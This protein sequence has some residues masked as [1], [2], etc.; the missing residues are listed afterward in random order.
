MQTFLMV[1]S[2]VSGVINVIQLLMFVMTKSSI[3][4]REQSAYNDWYRVA[5][6]ADEMARNPQKTP[7]LI[8]KINGMADVARNEIKAFSREKLGFVPWLDP[9]WDGGPHPDPSQG[10]WQKFKSVF[11]PK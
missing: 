11:T 9:A 1:L 10:L 5:Q 2:V 7:D 3:R 6:I 8:G 4:V